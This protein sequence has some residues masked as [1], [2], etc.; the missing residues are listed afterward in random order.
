VAAMQQMERRYD[1][2]YFSMIILLLAG[3]ILSF[4]SARTTRGELTVKS[5]LIS[6]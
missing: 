5:A 6:S 3:F 2:Y 4:I 1:F